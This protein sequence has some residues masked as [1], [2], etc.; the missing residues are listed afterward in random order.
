MVSLSF[1]IED[2]GSVLS[3][4]RRVAYPGDEDPPVYTTHYEYR[5]TLDR[6]WPAISCDQ[7]VL[8]DP[9]YREPALK[10]VW[11]FSNAKMELEIQ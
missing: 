6:R 5:V 4:T 7:L 1:A 8:D 3:V 10:D 2:L 11:T 9:T